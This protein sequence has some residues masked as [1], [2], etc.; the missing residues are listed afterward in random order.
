[1]LKEHMDGNILNPVIATILVVIT[2]LIIRAIYYLAFVKD[3][4]A[5]KKENAGPKKKDGGFAHCELNDIMGYDFIQVITTGGQ[6]ETEDVAPAEPKTFADSKGIGVTERMGTTGRDGY[7][8]EG[9][10]PV[11]IETHRRN[12]EIEKQN[13][14]LANRA[15]EEGKAEISNEMMERIAS[16][17]NGDWPDNTLIDPGR[18][19]E[20]DYL[21]GSIPPE[22]LDDTSDEGAAP[23]PERRLA[24]RP[25]E[26]ERYDSLMK[27][28]FERQEMEFMEMEAKLLDNEPTPDQEEAIR[29]L[30]NIGKPQKTASQE[31]EA[32]PEPASGIDENDLPDI[33]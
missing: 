8:F 18:D 3:R 7:D 1:M 10:K 23:D 26:E 17:S 22:D 5:E 21:C 9:E 14:E 16:I 32:T 31:R 11:D 33:D 6:K 28:V 29:R 30:R 19:N 12:R 24:D 27:D 2:I 15:R 20:M 4:R 25:A 13:E